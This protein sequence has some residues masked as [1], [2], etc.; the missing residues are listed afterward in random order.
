MGQRNVSN[1]AECLVEYSDYLKGTGDLDEA[2][3]KLNAAWKLFYSKL[4]KHSKEKAQLGVKKGRFFSDTNRPAKALKFIKKAIC[5]FNQSDS[6]DDEQLILSLYL[7]GPI[8][9]GLHNY[10]K[11]EK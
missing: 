5:I 7:Q 9:F 2:E 4:P 1:Q 10:R 6:P 3:K 11:A 8:C